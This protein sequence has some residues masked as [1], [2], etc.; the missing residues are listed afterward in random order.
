MR[1]RKLFSK[2]GLTAGIL[3]ALCILLLQSSP[4]AAEDGKE[5]RSS[6]GLEVGDVFT[7]RISNTIDGDS[8]SL[9]AEAGLTVLVFWA[10]W[11][12]R[13]G[14][15][16][17]M[18]EKY[19]NEY[20][21]YPLTVI[22]VN[23]EHQDT[24]EATLSS[25]RTFIEEDDVHLPVVVDR[26]LEFF[27]EIGIIV[28]PTTL[29]LDVHG[30]ILYKLPS[31][32]TSA[33][34]D[35][36]EELESHLGLAPPPEVRHAKPPAEYKPKN[37]AHLYYNLAMNLKRMGFWLKARH[38]LIISI[39]RDSAYTK[40]VKALEDDFF[41]DG[42]TPEAEKALRDFLAENGLDDLAGKY[43]GE[44]AAPV[45][46]K[47]GAGTAGTLESDGK[48]APAATKSGENK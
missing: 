18:W 10:T 19:Q 12:S 22:S 40:P 39:K 37:N 21:R 42:R 43:G 30:K 47:E 46:G 35:L 48:S 6:R 36:K 9:P 8:I 15:A 20:S 4:V 27:N 13:S 28:L 45:T 7:P 2:A 41:K 14:A 33:V 38:R 1:S 29:F 26:H 34:L 3:A 23:A 25:I 17:S 32:P 16:L 44:G 24:T 31:F 11:S 5:V